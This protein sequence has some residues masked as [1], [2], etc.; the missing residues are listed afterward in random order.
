MAKLKNYTTTISGMKTINEIEEL[1][2]DFGAENFMKTVNKEKKQI[3]S[4]MFT[5]EVNGKQL[6][7][8]LPANVDKMRDYL[9]NQYYSKTRRPRKEI[10][11]FDTDAYN[12]AWRLIKDWVHA[13]LSI[14]ESSM[15]QPEEVF[16]P[17]LMIDKDRTLSQKFLSGE[18][19]KMIP[20]FN[21]EE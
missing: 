11:D 14:I 4:I 6:P 13:Q 8:K 5:F 9:Y 2:L 21:A 12:I 3:K 16:L 1:L 17:Y 7:F 15:V 20:D 10:E 19:N 18:M